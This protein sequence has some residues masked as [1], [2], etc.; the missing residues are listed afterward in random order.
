MSEKNPHM[1]EFVADWLLVT[2]GRMWLSGATK[3]TGREIPWSQIRA[4]ARSYARQCMEHVENLERD[5]PNGLPDVE[6]R[7]E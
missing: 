7:D 3:S 6:V 1:E 2:F 4:Q 5:F